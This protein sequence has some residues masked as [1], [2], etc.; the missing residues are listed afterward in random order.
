MT[1]ILKRAALALALL[2]GGV[3]AGSATAQQM[4]LAAPACNRACLEG[5]ADQYLK[6][7][8]AHDP[9]KAPI[10]KTAR[11]TENSVVL[12][13]PD[14]VWRTA[15]G[16]TSYRL[17]VVDPSR[18][19]IGFLTRIYE[20]G[21]PVLMSTRLEVN[22]DKIT[23]IETMVVRANPT[24]GAPAPAP[25]QPPAA[26]TDQLGAA[27]R[28]QFTQ[29]LAPSER[30]SRQDMVEIANSYF[31]A[32]E[33]NDGSRHPPFAATCHRLENGN[34]TTNRPVAA[35]AVRGAG[36]M[37]CAEG[38]ATGNYRID[39]RLWH[40]RFL[41]ID[42]EHGLVY[43]RIS[44]DH[45]GSVRTYKLSDGRVVNARQS[46][47]SSWDITEVFQIKNGMIDQVEALLVANPYGQDP[48]WDDGIHMPSFGY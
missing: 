44:F 47:T 34:P 3:V 2:G 31:S 43:A 26:I 35:G 42:E 10:A 16:L 1:S 21:V 5:V 11:Y 15:S 40:R 38:F 45:D 4:P 12:H 24:G 41:A 27:P 22:D 48:N 30:R 20:N 37:G 19:T 46:G 8:V 9:T 25:G 17:N 28:A 29:V 36:N 7:L 18:N 23:K 39:T 32:L 33:N 6:A 14:G 13:L